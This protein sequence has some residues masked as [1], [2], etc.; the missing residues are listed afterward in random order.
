MTKSLSEYY[1]KKLTGV[2]IENLKRSRHEIENHLAPDKT[3]INQENLPVD[4]DTVANSDSYNSRFEESQLESS[5]NKIF[6]SKEDIEDRT[7]ITREALKHLAIANA[8]DRNLLIIADEIANKAKTLLT[9]IE[10]GDDSKISTRQSQEVLEVVVAMDGSRPS[11]LVQNNAVTLPDMRNTFWHQTINSSKEKLKGA[12]SS[13]GKISINGNGVGTGFLIADNLVVTNRHVLEGISTVDHLGRRTIFPSAEIGFGF[14]YRMD[15]Q[16]IYKFKPQPIFFGS[17]N[18]NNVPKH[19]QL[20]LALIELNPT[21][22]ILPAP[23]GLDLSEYWAAD[24]Q[25]IYVV[26]YPS[27]PSIALTQS[28]L[29]ELFFVNQFGF[30]RLAPGMIQSTSGYPMW[31]GCHDATTLGGNSGSAVLIIN[32]EDFVAGLHYGGTLNGTPINWSHILGRTLDWQ[33]EITGVTLEKILDRY[34][35]RKM[36]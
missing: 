22:I 33:D 26:G 24:D 14:E 15:P 19:D 25:F 9:A 18:F 1:R 30:K 16:S 8:C 3:K 35:I 11:F 34:S 21:G 20:D 10:K 27:R 2:P 28:S 36:N 29:L 6:L 17:H 5:N 13:I 32:N 23:L 12:L 7:E 4:L 31:T